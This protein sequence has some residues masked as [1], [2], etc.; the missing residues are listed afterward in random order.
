MAAKNCLLP[1]QFVCRHVLAMLPDYLQYREC[2][3][4]KTADEQYRF[5]V[6]I[7]EGYLGGFS[8]T[9]DEF[10]LS[11]ADFDE[12]LKPMLNE[13]LFKLWGGEALPP[14]LN[15]PL[16]GPE[17]GREWMSMEDE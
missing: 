11:I 14:K 15:I 13:G 17:A 10:R 7:G 9:N 4:R 1:P 8:L 12:I 16:D 2:S 6:N 3:Y 5:D